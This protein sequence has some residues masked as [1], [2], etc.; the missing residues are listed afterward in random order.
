MSRDRRKKGG[1]G[2]KGRGR[3]TDLLLSKRVPRGPVPSSVRFC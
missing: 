2:E 1:K 3:E